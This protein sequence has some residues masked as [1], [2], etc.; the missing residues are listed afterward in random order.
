MEI[1]L[2]ED[3]RVIRRSLIGLLEANGY[4][5]RAAADGEA[6]LRLCR[7][8]RPDLMLLDVVM[9]RRNGHEVCAAICIFRRGSPTRCCW[10]ASPQ[11]R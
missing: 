9:P 2:A 6:A 11:A 7:E 8:R 4:A 1:L 10:R 3:E 5:V